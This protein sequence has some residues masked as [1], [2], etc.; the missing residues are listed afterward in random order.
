MVQHYVKAINTPGAIPNVEKAW[1]TFVDQKCCEAKQAA[2]GTYIALLTSQLSGELPCD[3]NKIR[4]SH[5]A[6]LQACEEQ[7]VKDVAGI[8]TETVENHTRDL[9]V[10]KKQL[11]TLFFNF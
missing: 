1:D 2:L 7:F 10:R 3:N 8:S 9:K 4:L 5:N 6:A 11:T